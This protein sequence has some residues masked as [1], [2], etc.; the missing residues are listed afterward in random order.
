MNGKAALAVLGLLAA[1][2]AGPAE[3]QDSGIYL[4][5]SVGYAWHKD[6]CKNL[7][8]PCGST[9]QVARGFAG[10]RFNRA[11]SAELG[12][13]NLGEVRAEGSVAAGPASLVRS[14]RLADAVGVF[15]VPVV[16]RL[17]ALGKLG[18][19]RARTMLDVTV[20]GAP[21]HGGATNSG[22]SYGAGL[23]YDL[24]PFGV[25]AEWQRWENVGGSSTGED[26]I[27]ALTLG[28]LLRF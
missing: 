2:I 15:S 28:L 1:A 22:W 8:I 12:Y 14:V 21:A 13:A 27:D 17:S 4:G 9:E 26:D 6:A 3:A 18:I 25:R 24:G 20:A 11:A 5:A 10:Y 16:G 23:D 19:Y 7:Q